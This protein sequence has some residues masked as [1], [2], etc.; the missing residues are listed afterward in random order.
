MRQHPENIVVNLSMSVSNSLTIA[1]NALKEPIIVG[2]HKFK[3]KFQ[4]A[5]TY[6]RGRIYPWSSPTDWPAKTYPFPGR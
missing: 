3:G 4:E 2:L 6:H 1:S 5:S